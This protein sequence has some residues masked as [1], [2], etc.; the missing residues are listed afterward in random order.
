MTI[1]EAI[2]TIDT[3]KPNMIENHQKV[4]WLSDLDGMI[5]R[6]IIMKHEGVPEGVCFDGYDQDTEFGVTLLA[7]EPYADIYRHYMATQIDI[8]TRETN[9]YT[10]DMLLFNNAW[11]TLCDYWTRE[12]MPKS[13]AKELRF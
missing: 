8:A 1:Q 5:W 4:A 11:Q 2:D 10:K 9:E 6:E 7:P 3:L 12:H 13:K